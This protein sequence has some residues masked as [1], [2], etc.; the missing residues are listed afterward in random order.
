ML[1]QDRWD[2]VLSRRGRGE[3]S[4]LLREG[5][6]VF[7]RFPPSGPRPA[8]QAELDRSLR[9]ELVSLLRNGDFEE[10]IPD[11][12][13]RGWTVS[14]PR[15]GDLGWPGWSQEGP[16]SGTSCLKFVRPKDRI[17]L[18]S[19][20]MRLRT[21]GT[22]ELRFKAKGTATQASVTVKGQRGTS[23]KV[24]IRPT[25]EWEDY[26]TEL[27]AHTGYCTVSVS[28]GSGGAAD[29]VVWVDDMQ[30]GPVAP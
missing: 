1:V 18:N 2:P 5:A 7:V 8:V 29:Q 3:V 23:A 26:G 22:Y 10:G 14:H 17:T 25:A 6:E 4:A 20:P 16:F 30:F 12:P 24:E 19:Q 27:E 28:F 21:G 11:Y 15:T 13:P 9:G